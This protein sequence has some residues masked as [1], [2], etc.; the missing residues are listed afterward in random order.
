[1]TLDE[2]LY[3]VQRY[4]KINKDLSML[5]TGDGSFIKHYNPTTHRIHGKIDT[6]GAGTGR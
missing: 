3:L 4:L 2:V 5:H 6:L 1:M